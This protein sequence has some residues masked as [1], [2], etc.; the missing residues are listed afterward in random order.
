MLSL[1]KPLIAMKKPTFLYLLVLILISSCSSSQDSEDSYTVENEMVNDPL[2]PLTVDEYFN[3]YSSDIANFVIQESIDSLTPHWANNM[4]EIRVAE[5]TASDAENLNWEKLSLTPR[6]RDIWDEAADQK[7]SDKD[8]VLIENVWNAVNKHTKIKSDFTP[9]EI[10]LYAQEEFLS[11]YDTDIYYAIMRMN[12]NAFWVSC[13]QGILPVDYERI[14]EGFAQNSNGI[15]NP[16]GFLQ[17]NSGD[18]CEHVQ[19]SLDGKIY[20]Y[21]PSN[22]DDYVDNIG[23]TAA[24]NRALF[25][26]GCE[27]RFYETSDCQFMFMTPEA[28]L[29][30]QLEYGGHHLLPVSLFDV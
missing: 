2:D 22:M 12:Q 11:I 13:E 3:E 14:F 17:T 19:F 9:Q 27:E 30:Y 16:D 15:F 4:V 26:I 20:R 18:V 23:V 29:E 10:F 8:K 25:E 5:L 6:E 7:M 1:T 28:M 21:Y 24:V